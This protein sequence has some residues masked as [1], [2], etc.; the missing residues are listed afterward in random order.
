MQR[1]R[2]GPVIGTPLS[3]VAPDVGASK[4]AATRSKVVLPHPEGPTKQ[5]NSPVAASTLTPV[6]ATDERPSGSKYRTSTSL[7]LRWGTAT[8]GPSVSCERYASVRACQDADRDAEEP[9]EQQTQQSDEQYDQE[10]R[11][12]IVV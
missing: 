5:T 2:P 7:N 12:D 1:S 4:P 9:I 6:T 8:L 11:S 3:S 10:H